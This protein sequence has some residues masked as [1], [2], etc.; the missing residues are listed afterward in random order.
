MPICILL[1][2]GFAIYI[3][4]VS[5]RYR[6][7]YQFS[8]LSFLFVIGLSKWS[9]CSWFLQN[10]NIAHFLLG[11][12]WVVCI[13]VSRV[14]DSRPS[15]WRN[16]PLLLGNQGRDVRKY[17]WTECNRMQTH[18]ICI[19]PQLLKKLGKVPFHFCI[20]LLGGMVF[21]RHSLMNILKQL[22]E[23]RQLWTVGSIKE[24]QKDLQS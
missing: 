1:I 20:P 8:F 2:T 7:T 6:S 18:Y 3:R 19:P 4:Q 15:W 14:G 24:A 10:V 22:K 21:A 12:Y 23:Q 13:G 11:D 5:P 17:K 9:H 16:L